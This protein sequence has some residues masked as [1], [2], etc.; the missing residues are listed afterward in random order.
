MVHLSF[1]T[2]HPPLS[3][4][5]LLFVLLIFHQ[6]SDH[7]AMPVPWW[8]AEGEK[9]TASYETEGDDERI[10]C[11]RLDDIMR[12]NKQSFTALKLAI[13]NSLAPFLLCS[14]PSFHCSLDLH[15]RITLSSFAISSSEGSSFGL[16]VNKDRIL[17]GRFGFD[18]SESKISTR[19]NRRDLWVRLW[20]TSPTWCGRP[21]GPEEQ[22]FCDQTATH[23]AHGSLLDPELPLLQQYNW[24]KYIQCNL[25]C[26]LEAIIQSAFQYGRRGIQQESNLPT[27]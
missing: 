23:L 25:C 19:G 12:P 3:S 13:N 2:W 17:P 10:R 27:T 11:L 18:C 14:F 16:I 22:G 6:A 7:K 4:R 5:Y 21:E 24:H 1:L 8:D 15:L 26:F 20:F 9:S